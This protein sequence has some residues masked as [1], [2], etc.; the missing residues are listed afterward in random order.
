[1]TVSDFVLNHIVW[2]NGDRFHRTEESKTEYNI[3]GKTSVHRMH[4]DKKCL[5]TFIDN[6][7]TGEC[8]LC[9]EFVSLW[10][11]N[12]REAGELKPVERHKFECIGS[13]PL[14]CGKALAEMIGNRTG[15][16]I[17]VKKLV[18]TGK[19]DIIDGVRKE[20]VYPHYND[21]YFV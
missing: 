14:V 18:H 4:K 3:I 16:F 5:K 7:W 21:S 12:R 13:E 8:H 2:D 20:R 1:M 15:K 9:A 17:L 19:Y 11:G 10:N 6:K